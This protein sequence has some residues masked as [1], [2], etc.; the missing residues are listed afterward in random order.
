MRGG[1]AALMVLWMSA[2]LAERAGLDHCPQHDPRAAAAMQ[3]SHHEGHSG[4]EH[5]QHQKCCCLEQCACASFFTRPAGLADAPAPRITH[6]ETPALRSRETPLPRVDTRLP[7][8]N[9][10]PHAP[11]A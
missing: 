3:L 10:P 1:S 4:H 11:I 5:G 6:F 9:G 2:S 8:A 7:F